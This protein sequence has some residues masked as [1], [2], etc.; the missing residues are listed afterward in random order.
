MTETGE[1]ARTEIPQPYRFTANWQYGGEYRSKL[2]EQE[3]NGFCQFCAWWERQDRIIA[4]VNGW[5]ARRRD[6]PYRGRNNVPS[7]H[8]ILLMPKRHVISLDELTEADA[9]DRFHLTRQVKASLGI[10]GWGEL[11]RMDDPDRSGATQLHIHVHMV[12]PGDHPNPN[13]DTDG[14]SDPIAIWIG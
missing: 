3:R 4:E 8:A 13:P 12:E 1:A 7:R 5:F 9:Y 10:T 2:E 14:K 11:S 6:Y